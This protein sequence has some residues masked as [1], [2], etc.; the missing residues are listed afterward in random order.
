M[1]VA[2]PTYEGLAEELYNLLASHP[3]G[4]ALADIATTLGVSRRQA[5]GVVRKLRL[6]LG[7]GNSINVPV[8]LDAG[9]HVY[10]LTDRPNGGDQWQAVRTKTM[11]S[12]IAVDQA[13]WRSMVAATNGRTAEGRIARAAL[14]HFTRLGEDLAEITEAPPG[15]VA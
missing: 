14:R 3:D 5:Q 2:T 10:Y 9:R 12:R 6:L 8:R 15:G 11:V 7:S 4:V 13:W 1:T